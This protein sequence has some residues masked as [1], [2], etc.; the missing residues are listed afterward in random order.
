MARTKEQAAATARRHIIERPRL[1]RM[2]DGSTARVIMLVAPAGYGKTTLARQWLACRPHAWYAADATSG[3]VGAFGLGLASAARAAGI[4]I[5][6]RFHE[7][8]HARRGS[9]VIGVAAS[10]LLD[11]LEEWPSEMW[12]AID[13][14]HALP[15]SVEEVIR[16]LMEIE[17]LRLLLTTRRRPNW[18]TSRRVLYGEVFELGQTSLAMSNEEARQVL[19]AIDEHATKSVLARAEGWPAIIGL[20][21]FTHAGLRIERAAVP[22]ALHA[23]I[24]D[25]LFASVDAG[26]RLDLAKLALLSPVS[27]ARA[28]AL[29]GPSAASVLDEGVRVGFLAEEHGGVFSIHPLLR[30]FLRRKL[31]ELPRD[32]LLAVASS[33]VR[34]LIDERSWEN[35]FEL[36]ENF[37]LDALIR[38]LVEESLYDLLGRGL[39]STLSKFLRF[40]RGCSH[41]HA[42]FDLAEAELA[43]R[44]GFHLRSRSLAEAAGAQFVTH[45]RLGSR[46]F[47]RAGQGAYFC[48][49]LQGAV[50]NFETARTLAADSA[51]ERAA[52]WGLFLAAVEQE[53]RAAEELLD[54][55]ENL[56]ATIADDA[57][58][59]QNG[60]L[61]Y[62]MRLGTLGRALGETDA[63]KALVAEARD[64]V[65]R[66]SFW[67]VYAGAL[68]VAA[69][70]DRA[71]DAS[72]RALHEIDTFDL[73]F[74]RAHIYLTR[75]GVFLGIGDYNA[76]TQLLANAA[77]IGRR[78]GDV[79]VQ[80]N[81]RALRCRLHL[82][83]GHLDRASETVDISWSHVTSSGQYAEF[84][85][86]RALVLAL[87]AHEG[88][89]AL[90]QLEEAEKLSEENEARCLCACVRALVAP[91]DSLD[92]V[93]AKLA[94]AVRANILDPVIF[95]SR[96]DVRIADVADRN[97]DV[98][99]AI[100]RIEAESPT[101]ALL[102]RLRERPRQWRLPGA[103]ALTPREHEVLSL[104]AEGLTN[105]EIGERLFLTEATVK[106]H[107]RH[108][109]SKLRVRTRTEAVILVLTKRRPVGA[110]GRSPAATVE[111]PS[112]SS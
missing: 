79:Y 106:V 74:A 40:A 8:L 104:L 66:T 83:T 95:G 108:I 56:G 57:L 50:T 45:P 72:D 102:E 32:E 17:R 49:D 51:E 54:Q 34:L 29:L 71:L 47:C 31:T 26:A 88:E 3:D 96:L 22:P 59:L 41:A 68:R 15:R 43:F 109:L 105:S 65:V 2:L 73:T 84:V 77:D 7:W 10:H 112:E 98:R 94:T 93:S 13:D 53:D 14:Y 19:D 28:D 1:T 38:D 81:E 62:G 39:L 44:N 76:A 55:F 4:E 78:T 52:V 23:Y 101:R 37:D 36:I 25:E 48:D 85:A 110:A 75:A 90:K 99:R 61:H 9:D 69:D 58:R 18:A 64:P 80:M 70:Y 100:R 92:D 86:C 33:A 20:A 67:H 111:L 5:G 35:A 30:S 87:S 97:H 27:T 12:L 21:S 24:A 103:E 107:V 11:D 16:R 6:N 91:D 42:V 60:R 89:R 82:L 63:V 46:A